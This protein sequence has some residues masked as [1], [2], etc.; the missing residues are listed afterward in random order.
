MTLLLIE[1]FERAL[2]NQKSIRVNFMGSE[3]ENVARFNRKF[4]ATDAV[5]WEV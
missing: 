5:Y 4:G 3:N 1:L 2:S